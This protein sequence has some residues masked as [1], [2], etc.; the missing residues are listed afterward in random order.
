MLRPP[1]WRGPPAF[2]PARLSVCRGRAQGEGSAGAAGAQGCGRTG[3]LQLVQRQVPET[4]CWHWGNEVR[5]EGWRGDRQAGGGESS[6]RGQGSGSLQLGAGHRLLLHPGLSVSLWPHLTSA[7]PF[8]EAGKHLP[9]K[10]QGCH[11]GIPLILTLIPPNHPWPARRHLQPGECQLP[12]CSW[13]VRLHLWVYLQ[14]LLHQ[15][16]VC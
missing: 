9:E 6:P 5:C 15:N 3:H 4:M 16:P 13:Q 2:L 11:M 8:P 1:A 12:L 7:E 10:L 14:N